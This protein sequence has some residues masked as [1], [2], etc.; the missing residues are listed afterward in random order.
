MTTPILNAT[1]YAY[2]YGLFT[3]LLP[4][5]GALEVDGVWAAA[6]I[7]GAKTARSITKRLASSTSSGKFHSSSHQDQLKLT[8]IPSTRTAPLE[9]DLQNQCHQLDPKRFP[10]THASLKSVEG[11]GGQGVV[12]EEDVLESIGWIPAGRA[13]EGFEVPETNWEDESWERKHV[14]EDVRATFGKAA[15]GWEKWVKGF[16]KDPKKAESK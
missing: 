7:K 8:F 12:S 11:G 15:K 5:G 9:S 4:S 6:S 10:Q 2:H 16:E 1:S 14:L 13:I 3:Y